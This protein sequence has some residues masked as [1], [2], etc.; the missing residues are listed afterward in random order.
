MPTRLSGLDAFFLYLETPTMHLHVGS[1]LLLDP[2]TAP[3]GTVTRDDVAA[4]VA[5]RLHLAPPFRRRLAPVPLRLDHPVWVEDAD[6]D[7]DFHVRRASLPPPGGRAELAE[8]TG[9]VMSRGIDRSRPLWELYVVDG[10]ADG[11]VAL[12]TKTH[13]AAVDG[14]SGVELATALLQREPDASPPPPE[15]VWEP[16]PAPPELLLLLQAGAKLVTRPWEAV[17]VGRQALDALADVLR[18][19]EDGGEPGPGRSPP[20]PAPFGAPMTVLNGAIGPHRRVALTQIPL[21]RV[22]DVK[23]RL[24][25]TVNDVVL[26]AAA[27]ALRRFLAARGER[28][29]RPLVA[30]VPISV[31]RRDQRGAPGN[32]LSVMLVALPV[33]EA[34]PVIRL[35]R[36]RTGTSGAKEQHGALGAHTLQQIA[37]IA[38]GALQSLAARLYT[39]TRGADRHR[40]I[41]NVVVSN[42]PG[43]RS[44]L[45]CAGARLEAMYPLGPV[46]EMCGLNVTLFSYAGTVHVGLN[47]D[48][49]LLPDVEAV[50][51]AFVDAVEELAEAGECG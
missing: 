13:H 39:R 2:A 9:D 19:R 7:V 33:D 21:A 46:H 51:D 3:G 12:V 47:A 40:P 48:R 18:L 15:R 14:I 31:R 28:L 45:Y 16:E 27:G 50:A 6:F 17:R 35:R 22:K 10:L 43:P 26:A 1:V 42:V 30:M 38:P 11:R 41:W 44:R 4:Y 37:E 20:P 34:D 23:N 24:G 36:V 8:V 32:H 25:G 49:D 29:D 5:A